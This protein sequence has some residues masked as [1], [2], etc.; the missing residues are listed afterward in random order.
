KLADITTSN[1][2]VRG[3]SQGIVRVRAWPGLPNASLGGYHNVIRIAKTRSEN[4]DHRADRRFSGCDPGAP[5]ARFWG[6]RGGVGCA[7]QLAE[8]PGSARNPRGRRQSLRFLFSLS[9]P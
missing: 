5:C 6:G 8:H 7:T 3:S 2:A 1:S 9:E 4:S